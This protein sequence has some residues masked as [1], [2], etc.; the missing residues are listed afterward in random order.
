MIVF[1]ES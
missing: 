1:C